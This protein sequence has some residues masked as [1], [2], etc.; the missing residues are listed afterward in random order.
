MKTRLIRHACAR[1]GAFIL[2]F[3]LIF[4][5]FC[6][7]RAEALRTP[8]DDPEFVE[9]RRLF[10]SGQYIESDKLF[11][12]YLTSHPDHRAT[13]SFLQMIQQWRLHDTQKREE[14]DRQT[15][16]TRERLK[17]IRVDK[18]KFEDVDWWTVSARLQDL[19]NKKIDGNPPE[20]PILF[21]N[22]LPPKVSVKVSMEIHDANLLDAIESVCRKVG[23]RYVMDVWAV[24]FDV[25]PPK[26]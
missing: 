21:I 3:I 19:A 4:G 5:G 24:I 22:M 14:V 18:L 11:H 1:N 16:A 23:L 25:P 10:W 13:R 9:A 20:H 15:A 7:L 26:K 17:K 2:N 6:D 8:E 12:A